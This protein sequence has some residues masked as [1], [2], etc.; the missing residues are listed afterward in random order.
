MAD[1]TKGHGWGLH[2]SM[3]V[4]GKNTALAMSIEIH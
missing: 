1:T 2:A 3:Y 4:T